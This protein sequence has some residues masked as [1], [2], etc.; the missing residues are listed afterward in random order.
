[1]GE[2]LGTELDDG[3][4][5]LEVLNQALEKFKGA[6]QREAQEPQEAQPGDW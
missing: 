5:A 2:L 3:T 4:V 1:M 6:P